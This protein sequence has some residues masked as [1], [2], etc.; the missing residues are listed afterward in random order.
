MV[1][2]YIGELFGGFD[3]SKDGMPSQTCEG[4]GGVVL[5]QLAG[6]FGVVTDA[7][8]GMIELLVGGRICLCGSFVKRCPDCNLD[9]L[10][11]GPTADRC[12]GWLVVQVKGDIVCEGAHA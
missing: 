10:V 5:G 2:E 9:G 6:R 3:C 12:P 8:I 11:V 7:Q 4:G 1:D